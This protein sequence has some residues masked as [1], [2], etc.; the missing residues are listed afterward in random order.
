MEEI[1]D[2]KRRIRIFVG[3]VL[4]AMVAISTWS[5][6]VEYRHII[7]TAERQTAGYAQALSEHAESSF[8]EA[9]RVARDV[10]YNVGLLG[11]VE[12]LGR[13]QLFDLLH[14]QGGG[15]PQIGTLFMVDQHG[16]M[17]INSQEPSRQIRVADREYFRYYLNNPGTDL[18]LS[19]PV[20]SRLVHRW[21]FNLI[22]PLDPPDRQFAGFLAVAF[23]VNY[24]KRFFSASSL[25]PRGRVMLIRDD[26]A[27]LVFEPEVAGIYQKDFRDSRLFRTWLP[28]APS[29]TFSVDSS[30]VDRGPRIISYKRLSRFP[31]V[32]VVSLN[33]DD[34]LAPWAHKSLLQAAVTVALCIV[35]LF[36]TRLMFRHLDR[37]ETARSSFREQQELVRVKAAQIDAANDAILQCDLAGR[38]VHFNQALCKIT[39][40]PAAKLAA[41]NLHDLA[42]PEARNQLCLALQRVESLGEA[43]F[44]SAYLTRDGSVVPMEVHAHRMES[45]GTPYILSIARDVHERKQ[46]ERREQGRLAI[47][48]E[49]ATGAALDG[50][51]QHIVNFAEQQSHGAI[52]SVLL[53]DETGSRLRH[54]AAPNLPE[55]YNRA[56]DGL[57]IREG[58][59][60]CG[61]AA[62][63][64][65][66]V[67]VE[68]IE[69]HPYWKGFKPACEAGLRAC[70]STPIL[71][72]DGELLGT[73]AVY[74]REPRA[75]S[76]EEI[77]LIESAAHLASIAIGRVREE[78][79]RKL[80]EDQLRHVQKIEAI[81]QLTGGIAHDFNNLLT[82]VLVYA[83]M[84][85]S[86][87]PAESTAR[88]MAERI[89]K[90]AQKARELTQKLLSFGRRQIL[91]MQ[92]LDLNEVIRSF[93]DILRSTIRENIAIR[94]VLATGG[95]AVLADRGQVEQILLNLAVNAQ[96]AISG[97]GAITIETGH[98][99]LDDEYVRLHPG[100]RPGPH[101]MLSF[102]DD[103]CGMDDR[104]LQHIFE[105]FFTT[106]QV[107]HGTGLG[108][109]TVYGVVK[110][111]NGYI[112][113][114][115]RVDSGTTFTIYLPAND[116]VAPAAGGESANADPLAGVMRNKTILVVE[117]N[118][119]VREMAV[120]LLAATGCRVLVAATPGEACELAQD[121]RQVID[122]LVTDVVMPEMDGHELYDR[123]AGERPGLP[124]LFISGYTNDVVVHNGTLEEGV[125]FLQKPFTRE[126]F[127]GEVGRM[128]LEAPLA[129]G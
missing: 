127:I 96:D 120:E 113:V 69:S 128:L 118:E 44:E 22:R 28:K 27:P 81:G 3:L 89:L 42:P 86:D 54:G 75:P 55:A 106:K 30:V 99:L 122:L 20:M 48:E 88:M 117:D 97:N 80:L 19:K 62:H 76:E 6:V 112:A 39:G 40:F 68:D 66:R 37:L 25:G 4:A 91:K 102:V 21:R 123:L 23:E 103:G 51:L 74:Y 73:F 17:F 84:I 60:S 64:K 24:F 111:H 126:Q 98:V 32:A 9:D 12:R 14:R 29:G 43:T 109:A 16:L 108:L 13:R 57:P 65:Q 119:M 49:M 11:G 36:L 18:Y 78:E 52:C 71:L 58:M 15:S 114:T 124:V 101:V 95:V 26:G 53:A 83:D 63:L 87:S 47:L 116:A 61:T 79:R 82:P 7:A 129:T 45:D 121:R 107:G 33:R 77:A 31:V 93:H 5:I 46:A 85:K 67:I 105:P 41:M 50:L 1:G 34:V 59:G 38:L 110:Q 8:A 72:S 104:T 92:L 115:S 2:L 10:V 90:A 70:W 125:N 35:I 94:L 100:M 56:V